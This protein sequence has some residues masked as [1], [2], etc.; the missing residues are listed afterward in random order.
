MIGYCANIV[1]R[2]PYYN[3]GL[4]MIEKNEHN[5]LLRYTSQY[6]MIKK[7]RFDVL[8]EIYISQSDVFDEEIRKWSEAYID[9]ME[10][11]RQE[12]NVDIP[13]RVKTLFFE[14]SEFASNE[15][16]AM[17]K[18][19]ISASNLRSLDEN[20]ELYQTGSREILYS[21]SY[22]M[23]LFNR[24]TFTGTT[25]NNVVFLFPRNNKR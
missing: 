12:N 15:N 9:L 4:F 6:F 16:E 14:V 3:G 10:R 19:L 20:V 24:G 25:Q 23:N 17:L 13:E 2:F 7:S 5:I 11:I 21:L 1:L 22:F 8:K 18:E